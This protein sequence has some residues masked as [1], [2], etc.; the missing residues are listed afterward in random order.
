MLPGRVYTA[1]KA[2]LTILREYAPHHDPAP[3]FEDITSTV[4]LP[5]I[6]ISEFST[7]NAAALLNVLI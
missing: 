4:G 5:P 1:A 2:S 3:T 7:S 6:A